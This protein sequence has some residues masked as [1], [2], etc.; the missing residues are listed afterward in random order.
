[1]TELVFKKVTAAF[2]DRKVTFEEFFNLMQQCK[3]FS[4]TKGELLHFLS[5]EILK[6]PAEFHRWHVFPDLGPDKGKH[7]RASFRCMEVAE[8]LQGMEH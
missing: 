4:M 6:K 2:E 8:R 3:M 7:I 5:L 1:M